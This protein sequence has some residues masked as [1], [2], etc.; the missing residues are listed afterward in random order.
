MQEERLIELLVALHEG[1]PRLGPGNTASTLRALK[2]CEDLPAAPRILD[3]GCGTGAQT[4]AL[5]SQTGGHI[6]ATDLF[7]TFLAQ[8]DARIRTQGLHERVL[9]QAAD[10]NALPFAEGSFDLIWSEGAVYIMGFDNGL[11][12]WRP[13]VKQ[14][15]YLVV[16][17][18]SWFKPEPPS[19]L[20]EF[21]DSN[22]P[23]MRTVEDNLIAAL[24]LGWTHV[25]NFHLPVEAWTIDYYGPLRRRLPIFRETYSRDQDAQ[26]VA[27]MT[28]HEMK[29]LSSYSD[30]YGYEFYILRRLDP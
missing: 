30:Y 22:Y 17:E 11:T 8:L 23:A 18:V 29:L 4:L 2:L 26:E 3:V 27:D 16:S 13:L 25:S 1:L 10:M 24:D 6:T 12:K 19:D 28:E 5:A 9:T 21:W 7:P 20:E 15:G 14:G